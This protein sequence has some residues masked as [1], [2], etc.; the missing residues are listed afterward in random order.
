[1][2]NQY[3]VIGVGSP[4]VDSL[5]QVED[6]FIDQLPGEKGGME[7]VDADRISELVQSLTDEPVKVAGGSAANTVAALT[8][9]GLDGTF[10]GKIGNDALG[11][12][13]LENCAT[14]GVD[15][16]RMKSTDTTP[17]GQCLCLVT[18]DS[19]RT[20]RT[21]LGAASM[22]TASEVSPADFQGAA[23]V[24]IEGYVLFNREL[25]LKVLESAKAA[26]CTIS[27]DL[28]S[29]EV[30]RANMDIM[31]DLLN[32]YVDMVFANEDE[33]EAY[34]GSNNPEAA[35]EAL[36][37]HCSIVAVKLG[38]DGA[39]L[40]KGA[41]KVRVEA[42]AVDAV[43]TTGAGD[44]WAA[45]FLYGH[46]TGQDLETCGRLGAM[47]G[48]EAVQVMGGALTDERWAAVKE[49][50]AK[51]SVVGNVLDYK[52]ASMNDEAEFRRLVDLGR[53]EIEIAEHEMP[54]LM[55]CCE[56]YGL[57]KPLAGAR[58][59]GSLH[60][61]IQTAVLIKTLVALGADVRWASCNIFSTQD[62]AAAAIAA[63]GVPVFA[64]K[65]ESL[66]E[67]W[68]CTRQ[69]LAFPDN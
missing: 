21:F 7:T 46:F 16:T 64:W 29:F 30:V 45:G 8:R 37:T 3:H 27:L 54:G 15:S 18:P 67:Y 25:T 17:T 6:A 47:L 60:M 50:T 61:T 26:G 42:K 34:L 33:A 51:C 63:M 32:D 5:A 62:H 68:W 28:A 48:A 58:I 57:E 69:A 11:K 43:D 20:C 55:A 19:E 24:H 9:L 1:M 38:A 44:L 52:V 10:L 49:E 14:A 56:K 40:K 35:L 65:G 22:L 12:F 39:W 41:E 36:A 66:E 4:L 31:N 13:Y 53:K 23:H 2:I 59:T